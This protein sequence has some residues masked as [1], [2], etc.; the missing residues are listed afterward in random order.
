MKRVVSFVLA[1]MMAFTAIMV[2]DIEVKANET[3]EEIALQDADFDNDVWGG[4]SA[5][6]CGPAVSGGTWATSETKTVTR[7]GSS[8]KVVNV[9]TQGSAYD[10]AVTQNV[11]SLEAGTYRISIDALGQAIEIKAK[12]GDYLSSEAIVIENE[13]STWNTFTREITITEDLTNVPVGF[14]MSSTSGGGQVDKI[15]L[16][17]V[18]INAPETEEIFEDTSEI[19]NGDFESGATDGWTITVP[20]TSGADVGYKVKVD[21][22]AANNTTNI[23]NIWNN[24]STAE[25]F[26]ISQKITSLGAGT[27]KLSFQQEGAVATSGLAVSVNSG[28][29]VLA[30]KMLPATTGWDKWETI[31][32]D[33]FVLSAKGDITITVSGNVTSGYWGDFD[34]FVLSKLV[35]EGEEEDNVTPVDALINVE[36]NKKV[37]EDF[38][39]GAD[40]SSYVSVVESGA[41]FYDFDGNELDGQGFF[42]LLK[43]SGLNY[44]RVRVWNNPYDADGNGYGGGNNDIETAK[45]IGQYATEAGMKLL[46]DFHYSDFWADPAKQQA[47]KAWA[48]Y[49]VDEKA[50]AVY[51]YTL[52]SLEYLV[53]AGVDVGMVQIGNETTGKICGESNW[54]NMSQIFNAGSKAVRDIDEDILVAIHVTNPEKSGSYANYAKNLDDYEVDYDVFASSYYPYWHGTLS[55]LTSVLKHVADT[56]GKQVFVAETSWAY[57]LEDGDGHSNTVRKGN[58]DEDMSYNFTVQG[59]ANE[60][61]A[62]I[63]AVTDV[64]EAGIGV[65]YWEAAWIPV[66]YAYDEDGKLDK[67][68]LASNKEAWEENGSGWASSFAA[69]YDPDDAGLWY[70]GS[71]V[72]NQALFDFNGKALES[73]K[74]F[75]YIKTGAVA[76]LAPEVTVVDTV[77]VELKDVDSLTMPAT[78]KVVYN[79]GTEEAV[80]VTWNITEVNA[81]KEAGIGEYE[82]NGTYSIGE[83]Q[84]EV[85]TTLSI[86][87]SNLLVNPSFEDTTAF[88]GWTVDGYSAFDKS[89]LGNNSKTGTKCLHFYNA[90][91][92]VEYSATQTVTLD[93]GIYEAGAFLQGGADDGTAKYEVRI[94]VGDKTYASENGSVTSWKNWLDLGVD[95]FVVTADDTE[96]TIE[97]YVCS[98]AGLWGS[99]DDAYI[100]KIGEYIPEPGDVSTDDSVVEEGAPNV[101]VGDMSEELQ[102]SIFTEEELEAIENG[103][104][105]S[106]YLEVSDKSDSVSTEEKELVEEVATDYEIG[107][108]IDLSLFKQVG[109]NNA[110]KVENLEAPITLSIVIPDNLLN[111]DEKVE[112]TYKIVRIHNGVATILNGTFDEETHEFTFETDG[113][114]TY[115]IVYADKEVDGNNP[116]GGGVVPPAG[117]ENK[118]ADDTTTGTNPDTGDTTNAYAYVLLM[119]SGLALLGYSV[120]RNKVQF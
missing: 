48:N 15:K 7:D 60:I 108:Y 70:G 9:W 8:V 35:V 68:I 28:T 4:S 64:G 43:E 46:V 114:S 51:D 110:S 2:G 67:D 107:V 24:N 73:L 1:V 104:D 53:D 40:V 72:D 36:R 112:R 54:T 27:Y 91:A 118:P 6:T 26:T 99:Y 57:T 101:T 90:N 69:E 45:V 83:K 31:E 21:Q 92:G 63:D 78:V 44:I 86:T 42:D 47:P 13:W 105:A 49:T 102:E 116:S 12:I 61:A 52:E 16:E 18:T 34:N 111:T 119:M 29:T 109:N 87:P 76:P 65:C 82:I 81:A 10:F 79:D 17:K 93:K 30:N 14:V 120:K 74:V 94:T 22:W 84:Y 32:T 66:E 23:F 62:V 85:V 75:N 96:V 56:Y 39:L 38:I 11:A 5:W 80:A 106:I 117:G 71:A 50:D 100:Y 113:F 77:E 19:L 37:D 33:A 41:K 55:N 3:V 103:D 59:Q 58:N 89:D 98:A 95:E 115:A 97:L 88:N 25:S 20:N